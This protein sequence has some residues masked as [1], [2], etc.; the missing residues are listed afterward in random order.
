MSEQPP[1]LGPPPEPVVPVSPDGW[2]RRT[3]RNLFALRSSLPLWQEVLLGALCLALCF[4]VWWYLTRGPEEERILS[5]IATSIYSP[6]E[7]FA[8]LSNLWFERGLTRNILVTLKRVT[9]G[10]GLAALIGVPL[11]VVCGCFAGV[12]AFF[13]P[14]TLFGRNIPIAA[15]IPLTFGLFGIE[16]KQKILFIVL[17]SV[18][19]IVSDT[20]RGVMEVGGAYIDTAYTLGAS[21]WQVI[22][23]VL[24][25]L[26][27]PGVFNSLRLLY[28]LAFGYIMLAETIKFGDETG[29]LGD[30]IN[31]SFK[32]GPREHILLVLLIIPLVALA[33]DRLLF[34]MQRE[35]FPHRYGGSGLLN[36]ALTLL[37]HG[38]DDVKSLFWKPS[39]AAELVLA[40]DRRPKAGTA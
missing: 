21:R 29:G 33:I 39:P 20:A 30:I 4:G 16:E 19:Y 22:R 23:K 15:L 25:P 9:L 34:W 28:G 8:E 3:T 24:V 31:T 35:L 32:R 17:A 36:R 5:S 13:M 11:G 6:K 26:A 40:Q 18:A 27:L 1:P 37:A 12:N 10:F 14:L 2:L 38:W 7:T